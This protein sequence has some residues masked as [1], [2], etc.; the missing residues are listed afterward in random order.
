MET[1]LDKF[2]LFLNSNGMGTSGFIHTQ[3][4]AKAELFRGLRNQRSQNM[5]F[6]QRY[7]MI[8]P[9]KIDLKPNSEDIRR[10]RTGRD[11]F[12]KQPSYIHIPILQLLQRLVQFDDLAHILNED[13]KSTDEFTWASYHD[14]SNFKDSVLFKMFPNALQIHLYLDEVQ[15]CNGFGSHTK[16]NKFVFVYFSLGNVPHKLRSSMSSIYLLSIFSN[17]QMNR[18]GL[19]VLLKPVIDDIKKLEM[20]LEMVVS[21]FSKVIYG[22]LTCVVADNLAS[23][24]IGGFKAGFAAGFRKC[25]TCL[26]TPKDIQTKYFHT[27]FIIRRK[28][29]YDL[30]I[31][32]LKVEKLRKHFSKLYGLNGDSILNELKYFHVIGGLVP[33]L[34]HDLLE[35]IVPLRMCGFLLE[36]I[37]KKYFDIDYLNNVILN[38]DYSYAEAREK[39]SKIEIQ[40]LKN[41]ILRQSSAQ[42]WLLATL[43]PL[44]IGNKVPSSNF[45]YQCF[46]TLLEIC[47][48]CFLD[49]FKTCDLIKLDLL[50]E[51]FLV[52]FQH[53]FKRKITP[54][55]HQLIHYSY[56]VKKMGPLISMWCMRYES[57]H[58]YFKQLQRS[59]GNYINIPLT[60]SMR[61]QQ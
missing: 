29:E 43:L 7:G 30:Q 16:K 34:M 31:E 3:F 36:C 41:K 59:I 13:K 52:S 39:P 26:T 35:G 48:L 56:H 32:G 28:E 11:Q 61:H 22:T 15:L 27:D 57:K 5:Y 17:V 33:D 9:Q 60:L 46:K 23:H 6:R 47:R 40:H 18:Y 44:M 24:Q 20:G 19:N 53:C 21:G 51:D 45:A 54:K 8:P 12:K 58:A 50:V 10:H 42:S 37:N 55:M 49:S 1:Q 2:K 4:D 14:G 38:F 25:R